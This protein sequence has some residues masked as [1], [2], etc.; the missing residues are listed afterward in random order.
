MSVAGE[1]VRTGYLL[2]SLRPVPLVA[3][4][5][6]AAAVLVLHHGGALTGVTSVRV[7]GLVLALGCG[8]LLDDPAAP[9]LQPSPYPLARRLWLRIA[10]AAAVVVPLWSVG[11]ILLLPRAVDRRPVALGLTVELAAGLTVVWAV[12]AWGRRRGVDE[13]G[14]ATAPAL[15]GLVFLA[16]MNPQVRLLVGPGPHWV[17]AHLR[18]AALLGVAAALLV[19][20]MRDPAAR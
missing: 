11:L 20:A 14:V 3:G 17:A 9:T 8:F 18:W 16:T 4:A 13:P 19:L 10:C 1:L 6:A 15:L 12:A 2:R 7:V 5:V